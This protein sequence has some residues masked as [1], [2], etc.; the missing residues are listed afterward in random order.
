MPH[1]GSGGIAPSV[2]RRVRPDRA[3]GSKH[4]ERERMTMMELKEVR[5]NRAAILADRERKHRRHDEAGDWNELMSNIADVWRERVTQPLDMAIDDVLKVGGCFLPTLEKH[6]ESAASKGA[7]NKAPRRGAAPHR[8]AKEV[9]RQMAQEVVEKEKEIHRK[10]QVEHK[11]MTRVR[12]RTNG[13]RPAPAAD[14]GAG[15]GFDDVTVGANSGG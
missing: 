5:N 14:D 9:A 1:L 3:L 2:E 11:R 6:E 4:I 15:V 12:Q 10:E 8:T 13:I 7:N